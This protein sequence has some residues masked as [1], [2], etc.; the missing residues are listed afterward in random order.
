MGHGGLVGVARKRKERNLTLNL[1]PV[2]GLDVSK[3]A[4]YVK[5]VVK[6]DKPGRKGV[7]RIVGDSI[8][9]CKIQEKAEIPW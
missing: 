9:L 4:T 1:Q 8:F 7:L 6:K 2:A 5:L 3:Y